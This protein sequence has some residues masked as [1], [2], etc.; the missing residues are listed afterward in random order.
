[1]TGTP[2]DGHARVQGEVLTQISTSLVE[3]HRRFYGKG[4]TGAKT[5]MLDNMVVCTLVGGVTTVE[6]TL[7]E[8]GDHESVYRTRLGFQQAMEDDFRRIVEE[9]TGRK[10]IAYMSAVHLD[11]ELTVELFVLEALPEREQLTD[12]GE[13]AR[14]GSG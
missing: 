3:L 5:E 14:S 1:V 7:I 2:T 13:F 8:A 11:P 4:P 6:R 12:S 10:V 9:S